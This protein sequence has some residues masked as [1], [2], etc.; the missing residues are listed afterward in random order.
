MRATLKLTPKQI[1]VLNDPRPMRAYVGGIRSGKT[2]I[3]AIDC[4]LR[5]M[6]HPNAMSLATA[7][8]HPQLRDVVIPAIW[9]ACDLLGVTYSWE[10]SRKIVIL[11]GGGHIVCRSLHIP[12]NLRGIEVGHWWGDEVRDYSREAIDTCLGRQSAFGISFLW[13]TTPAGFGPLWEFM[14]RDAKG[15]THCLIYAAT[16]DNPT[17]PSD[18]EQTLRDAY[19]G[20]PELIEQEIEGQFVSLKGTRCYKAFDRKRHVTNLAY[21]P[22]APLFLCIDW[23]VNP[24]VC[25]AAQET[26]TTREGLPIMEI[27]GEIVKRQA[28]VD[29]LARGISERFPKQT[30]EIIVNGD[31][32]EHRHSVQSSRTTWDLLEMRLRERFAKVRMDVP[33]KNPPVVDR[34]NSLNYLLVHDRLFIDKSCRMLIDDLES[35]SWDR[36]TGD[37]D[38]KADLERTHASDAVG[39]RA[40]REYRPNSFNREAARLAGGL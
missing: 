21:N 34:V 12:Q 18:Y 27:V 23:N 11:D 36:E 30:G 29:D 37:I 3:G 8:T 25:E 33:K 24:L 38:K 26:K 32:T 7:N 4:V 28:W 1:A 19:A 16:Y 39:Y 15:K 35:V 31:A 2:F 6:K 10:A 22:A 20:T 40:W 14:V 13:T 5:T 9:K 17:L